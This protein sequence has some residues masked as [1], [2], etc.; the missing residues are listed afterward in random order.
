MQTTLDGLVCRIDT[1]SGRPADAA[2]AKTATPTRAELL[3]V[4]LLAAIGAR[5]LLFPKQ[6]L[7]D[8]VRLT[9]FRFP[10]VFGM[11]RR[12]RRSHRRGWKR[13]PAQNETSPRHFCTVSETGRGQ[14]TL[15]LSV[16]WP[17]FADRCGRGG[18]KRI[19]RGHSLGHVTTSEGAGRPA[20]FLSSSCVDSISPYGRFRWPRFPSTRLASGGL[21]VRR[22]QLFSLRFVVSDRGA[23]GFHL[24]S[25]RPLA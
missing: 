18:E 4:W 23:R 2:G 22:V 9:H 11:R 15:S 14:A 20:S 21:P 12:R 6:G 3:C 25:Y 16:C 1:G 13:Q 17:A 7:A 5:L 19:A 8:L 10:L 24:R